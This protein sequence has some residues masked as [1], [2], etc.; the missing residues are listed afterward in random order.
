MTNSNNG[1]GHGSYEGDS[2]LPVESGP[3]IPPTDPTLRDV[4]VLGPDL[5]P[6]APV[7]APAPA[8]D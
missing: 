1:G 6:G 2:S 7:P 8:L 5:T 3:V 4:N